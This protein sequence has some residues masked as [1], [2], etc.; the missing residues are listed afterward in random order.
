MSIQVRQII[1]DDIDKVAE[2]LFVAFARADLALGHEPTFENVAAARAT[3]RGY[4]RADSEGSLL[5]EEDGEILGCGFLHVRGKTAGIGPVATEPMA[6]GK[7]V[8]R[9]IMRQLITIAGPDCSVRLVTGG[10]NLPAFTLYASLG[11]VVREANIG[12]AGQLRPGLSMAL[13][14]E[15]CSFMEPEELERLAKVD[16]ELTGIER[17]RDLYFFSRVGRIRL[18]KE[19]GQPTG[20]LASYRFGRNVIAGPGAAKDLDTMKKLITA[21]V[22]DHRD[23]SISFRIPGSHPELL[24][25]LRSLGLHITGVGHYMVHGPWEPARCPRLWPTYPESL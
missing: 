16:A 7:G 9:A 24:H 5:A 25:H 15:E 19:K 10:L 12:V 1:P 2:I 18:A 23:S 6:Q 4:M 8:G 14:P 22:L 3:T 21:V 17:P 20:F 13:D 11:F